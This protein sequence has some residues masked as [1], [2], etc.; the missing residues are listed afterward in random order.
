MITVDKQKYIDYV[1]T[2]GRSGDKTVEILRE[3]TSF[4][5][6]INTQIGFE[7]LKELCSKHEEI[8]MKISKLTATDID[9]MEYKVVYDLILRWGA[10]INAYNKA[11]DTINK[12]ADKMES[13]LS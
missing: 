1:R 6:A 4:I 11:V 3:N 9:R 7:L 10:H 13:K 5:E 8:L 12:D 2:K